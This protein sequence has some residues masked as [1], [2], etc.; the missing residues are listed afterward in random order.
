MGKLGKTIAAVFPRGSEKKKSNNDD[1]HGHDQEKK[2]T[3]NIK[4][5]KNQT[6]PYQGG[7]KRG[8]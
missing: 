1:K 2:D 7:L 4:L 5:W 3:H 8:P 6:N